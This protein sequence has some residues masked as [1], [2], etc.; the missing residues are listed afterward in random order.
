MPAMAASRAKESMADMA[1]SL[2]TLEGE[3]IDVVPNTASGK[4]SVL[5][6]DD[7]EALLDR[8]PEVFADR[9]LGW[10]KEGGKA[11]EDGTRKAAFA[12]Y[13]APVDEGNDA[14]AMNLGE[15]IEV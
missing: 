7:L 14:L 5:S 2:L 3:K 8:R 10:V 13:E 9:G 1:I 6:D 12:V 15:D 11:R 4:A